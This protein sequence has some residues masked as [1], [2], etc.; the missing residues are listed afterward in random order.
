[1]KNFLKISNGSAFKLDSLPIL[2]FADFR[3]TLIDS[4]GS[5][6]VRVAALFPME[7][8]NQTLLTAILIDS[9]DHCLRCGAAVTARSYPA[10]T[11][12]APVFHWF[13]RELFERYGITPE[14]HP[15]LKPIRKAD[16]EYFTMTGDA[17][18][19]VAVGPVH[20]GVIEPGHFRFQCMGEKVYSLEIS[21]GYQSRGVEKLLEGPLSSRTMPLFET[22][23]GDSAAAAATGAATLIE[24]LSGIVPSMGAQQLRAIMIELERVANHTGDLG[25]LAGDVAYLPTASFCGR[26]R[27]EYL[28]MTAEICGN[29]FGRN[30]IIPGGIRYEVDEKRRQ[31][32]LDWMKK[33]NA[34]LKHA[35]DLMFDSPTVLDRF[36]N[37][38][39]V[40]LDVASSIGL[41]G[42]AARASGMDMD[43]RHELPC[44]FY[45]ESAP[46]KV[47]GGKGDVLSRAKVRYDE[48]FASLDFIEKNLRNH[49]ISAPVG[50]QLPEL[51]S[52]SMAVAVTEAW[53]GELC[54]IM[55]TGNNGNIIQSRIVDPSFHNWF[56]LA[57]ALRDEEIS[58]F[59]ICNKSFNLSYCGHDL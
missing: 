15:W 20:A 43:I 28:N 35:L 21:L 13:E 58:N 12:E 14:T 56:G 3:Q 32:L 53:R 33:V 8:N 48:I 57:M 52:D 31:K 36:E 40:P 25:A 54:Q 27:G 46:E 49:E 6:K 18:N 42:V 1:M 5:E 7:L 4:T 19:E 37:T 9:A 2:P 38:G 30:C 47:P 59:P 44:G 16:G 26:I 11:P 23:A 45:K 17:V 10:L 34:E 55:I 24:A 41:V 39:T 22:A 51:Q 50:G 29:R